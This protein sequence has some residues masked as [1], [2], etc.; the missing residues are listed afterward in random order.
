[1]RLIASVSV[2][3]RPVG[4]PLREPHPARVLSAPRLRILFFH[5]RLPTGFFRWS[6]R[7][8]LGEQVIFHQSKV[9]NAFEHGPSSGCGRLG[10]YFF[11]RG[12]HSCRQRITAGFQRPRSCCFSRASDQLDAAGLN[13]VQDRG[14]C[15]D[16]R[17]ESR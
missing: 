17:P 8:N 15:I 12:R 5:V 9:F 3:K 10:G 16:I 11:G 4:Q 13:W 7:G 6:R 2:E 14:R 1:M